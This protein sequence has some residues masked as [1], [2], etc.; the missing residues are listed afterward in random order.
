TSSAVNKPGGSV[1]ARAPLF[2]A[3]TTRVTISDVAMK[4][5]MGRQPTM[6]HI[7]VNELLTNARLDRAAQHPAVLGSVSIRNPGAAPLHRLTA[8]ATG[9]DRTGLPDCAAHPDAA[10]GMRPI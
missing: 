2:P 9:G 7:L 3:R 8:W 10:S 6:L 5:P 4:R 1:T